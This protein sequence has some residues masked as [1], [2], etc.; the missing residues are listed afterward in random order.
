[1]AKHISGKSTTFDIVEIMHEHM[2]T[3]LNVFPTLAGGEPILSGAPWVLGNFVEIVPV[4]TIA[5]DFD[6]H[7]LIIENV[8]DDEI[9]EL[10][11][12][13]ATTE[14]ARVRFGAQPGIA[15]VVTAAPVP[16][17]ME[18]QPKNTQIQAKLASSGD[19]ETATVS[20]GYHTY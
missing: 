10:V 14:I 8:T 1:M 9:Y 15:A 12:Y 19:A 4:N 3:A 2:H 11:L 7:W 6:I 17:M 16:V 20:L 13:A 5:S 18:I